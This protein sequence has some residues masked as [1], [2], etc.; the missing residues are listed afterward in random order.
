[1]NPDHAALTASARE[2]SEAIIEAA[3]ELVLESASKRLIKGVCTATMLLEAVQE[4]LP[5]GS[6]EITARPPNDLLRS[7][8]PVP[9]T[10]AA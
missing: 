10:V 9:E 7:L 4:L 1:M 6:A 8:S 5:D 2:F 3:N